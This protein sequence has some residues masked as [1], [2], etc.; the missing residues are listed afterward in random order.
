[1]SR[2]FV[3]NLAEDTEVNARDTFLCGRAKTIQTQNQRA[4]RA[5]SFMLWFRVRVLDLLNISTVEFGL[6]ELS[7]LLEYI[8]FYFWAVV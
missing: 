5:T 3:Y 6:Y 2:G 4:L 7:R 8:F 1:M